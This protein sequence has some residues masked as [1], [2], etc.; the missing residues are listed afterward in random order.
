MQFL[1]NSGG[2]ITFLCM[3]ARFALQWWFTKVYVPEKRK[4]AGRNSGKLDWN[5]RKESIHQYYK[6]RKFTVFNSYPRMHVVF[7]F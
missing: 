4:I 7:F 3:V 2:T 1:K 6:S 5:E